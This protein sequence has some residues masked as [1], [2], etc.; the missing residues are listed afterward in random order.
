MEN[1]KQSNFSFE[2]KV[3]PPAPC[4]Q[5]YIFGAI[6]I[7]LFIISLLV[8]ALLVWI[9]LKHKSLHTRINYL[10]VF[11]SISNLYGTFAQ[12]PL[13]A[14]NAFNCDFI[15]SHQICVFMAFSLYFCGVCS[16]CILSVI[17]VERY[18]SICKPFRK[19]NHTVDLFVLIA[20]IAMSLFWGLTPLFGWS[21]YHYDGLAISCSISFGT[22]TKSML[23]YSI[24][25]AAF[26][27]ALPL[28]IFS[29][30][31]LTS[32]MTVSSIK[33]SFRMITLFRFY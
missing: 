5:F 7:V 33:S 25:F 30:T 9:I 2:V 16:N 24:V 29:Y 28:F 3:E 4:Y 11:L 23:S 18:K 32:I 6:S 12:F 14:M 10:I 8:N 31:N 26:G 22:T 21:E 19:N 13:I 15:F 20:S 1:G 17:S 27:F